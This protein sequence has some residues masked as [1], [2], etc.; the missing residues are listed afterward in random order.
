VRF[1]RA[2]IGIALA[3][4]FAAASPAVAQH[5]AEWRV[6]RHAEVGETV[7]LGGHVN[8]HLCGEVIPTTITIVQAPRYGT[9]SIRD[10]IVK[11]GHPELGRGDKC[12]GSSGQGKVVYYSRTSPGADK[13]RYD[14]SSDNGIVHV[15]VTVD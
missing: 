14:S 15:D 7:R 13:F 3:C 4:S 8:Y 12:R 11:S 2:Q 5:E 9:V 6:Q 1:N 10:E